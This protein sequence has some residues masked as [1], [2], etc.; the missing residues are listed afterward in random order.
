[1]NMLKRFFGDKSKRSLADE[2]GFLR[3]PI[4]EMDA[5]MGGRPTGPAVPAVA[6][7]T[8]RQTQQTPRNGYLGGE[9]QH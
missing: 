1:M 6:A 3:L 5:I 2:T 4:E 9:S 8:D 7:P